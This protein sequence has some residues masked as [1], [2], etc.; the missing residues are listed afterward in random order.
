MF[1]SKCGKEINADSTFC[2][3]CGSPT[4]NSSSTAESIEQAATPIV[5]PSNPQT[6]PSNNQ[7]ENILLKVGA[8]LSMIGIIGFLL[9]VLIGLIIYGRVYLFDGY[10]FTAV[11]CVL[12]IILQVSGTVSLTI[13]LITRGKWLP[14]TK[15]KAVFSLILICIAVICAIILIVNGISSSK[16]SKSSGYSY[17]GSSSYEMDHGTYCMLYMK[18]SNVK[19]T[20]SGNYAY[21]SGTVTNTGTYQIRY[22][23]VRAVCKNYKGTVIDTDWTYAVDSSWLNPGESK[24]FEMMV[25]DTGKDISTAT[26]TVV[27]E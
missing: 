16:P 11:L 22:V 13:G 8:I 4:S 18:I 25:K 12:C 7:K 24:K 9:I 23:K 26:V 15:R 5:T 27:S 14:P 21:I 20:H 1:C 19:V 2:I 17:S 6:K 10:T 3:Y